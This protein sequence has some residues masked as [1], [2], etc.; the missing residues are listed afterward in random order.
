M[1]LTRRDD[2]DITTDCLRFNRVDGSGNPG[3]K[4]ETTVSSGYTDITTLINWE[5]YWSHTGIKYKDFRKQI[6]DDYEPS[7]ATLSDDDKKTLI[8]HN[9]WPDSETQENLDALYTSQQRTDFKVEVLKILDAGHDLY[10][11][12]T[13]TQTITT[14]NTHQ[15]LNFSKNADLSSWD[16]TEGAAIFTCQEKGKYLC[17]V[18]IY[19]Q[20]TSAG[21]K[22]GNMIALY[23]GVEIVGSHS[24]VDLITNDE[25]S[26]FSSTFQFEGD[27]GKDLKIQIAGSATNV[28][29]IAGPN[30]GSAAEATSATINIIF[31][32]PP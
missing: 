17:I 14:A 21:A 9:H 19:M 4:R 28:Q 24:G 31:R 10:A 15:D 18:E 16:H 22:T 32:T 2:V 13:T 8:R 30:P 7:W 26:M 1:K 20:K 12:D 25:I 29:V 27:V 23:D 3:F 11:Y 6:K 5:L